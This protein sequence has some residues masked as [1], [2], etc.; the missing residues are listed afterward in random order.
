M[1]GAYPLWLQTLSGHWHRPWLSVTRSL[2]P[3]PPQFQ[4]CAA[5]LSSAPMYMQIIMSLSFQKVNSRGT[6]GLPHPEMGLPG[7]PQWVPQSCKEPGSSCLILCLSPCHFQGMWGVPLVQ[8]SG[9]REQ[10]Q[11]GRLQIGAQVRVPGSGDRALHRALRW[12][13]SLLRILCPLPLPPQIK[14]NNF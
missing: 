4:D 14:I 13:W 3:S 6:L 12:A 1:T 8:S 11:E 5:Q 9:I 10:W 7:S 2:I